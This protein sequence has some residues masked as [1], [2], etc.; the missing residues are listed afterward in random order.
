MSIHF[1]QFWM[2]FDYFWCPP[3]IYEAFRQHGGR[4]RKK[5]LLLRHQVISDIKL[6]T[7][8]TGWGWK[9]MR[10]AAEVEKL[11]CFREQFWKFIWTFSDICR[12]YNMYFDKKRLEYQIT[13]HTKCRPWLSTFQETSRSEQKDQNSSTKSLMILWNKGY[14]VKLRDTHC[15]LTQG[16]ELLH[17]K[18]QC[19]KPYETS[20]VSVQHHFSGLCSTGA[21]EIHLLEA[22][23]C[24]D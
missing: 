10:L 14:H 3:N 15:P 1:D 7:G 5:Q 22:K 23:L 4:F 2:M 13:G 9:P 20:T 11:E 8:R 16:K 12:T 24:L 6:A 17:P 19:I 18:R 21:W